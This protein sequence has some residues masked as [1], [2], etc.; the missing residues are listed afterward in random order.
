MLKNITSSFQVIIFGAWTS[1]WMN[2]LGPQAK[3]WQNHPNVREVLIIAET[4]LVHIPA[5]RHSSFLT[6]I[7]PLMEWHIIQC[8]KD[9]FSLISDERVIHTLGIKSEFSKY[10]ERIGYS[11]FCPQQYIDL[12][13]IKYPAVLKRVNKNASSGV[14][15]V[16]SEKNLSDH[17]NQELYKNQ[18]TVIQEFIAG[19]QEFVTHLICKN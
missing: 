19:E 9:Y 10:M 12:H 1:E 15:I 18:Q 11:Q 5:P 4:N 17:L 13:A 3:L 8:P 6:V 14:A 16:Q 7:L 2:A